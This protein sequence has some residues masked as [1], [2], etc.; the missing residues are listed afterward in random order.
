M[1]AFDEL[2]DRE[3]VKADA[4]VCD[5]I[6][7]IAVRPD[8]LGNEIEGHTLKGVMSANGVQ[9]YQRAHQEI[10][11]IGELEPSIRD[12]EEPD[13]KH[14]RHVL[15]NP[16]GAIIGPDRQDGELDEVQRQQHSR[17]S[18][19]CAPVHQ[20]ASYTDGDRRNKPLVARSGEVFTP[21]LLSRCGLGRACALCCFYRS[22]VGCLESLLMTRYVDFFQR[23]RTASIEVIFPDFL[24]RDMSCAWS[25]MPAS[26]K[27]LCP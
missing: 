2:G 25:L 12:N 22:R 4:E 13:D 3:C 21:R 7:V 10:R 23:I 19:F 9:E 5:A 20:R 11:E 24:P 18:S 1:P 14:N 16:V 6:E 17:Q 27:A 26:K 15:R 8:E